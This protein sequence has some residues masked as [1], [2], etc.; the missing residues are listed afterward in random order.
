MSVQCKD[1]E[2]A[3]NRFDTERT[4]DQNN[5]TAGRLTSQLR[6]AEEEAQRA[7]RIAARLEAE[8]N[9]AGN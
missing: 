2:Q 9:A 7:K 3:C 6:K 8:N 1:K 5:W 4:K